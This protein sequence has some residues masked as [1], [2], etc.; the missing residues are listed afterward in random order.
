MAQLT[1]LEL[2]DYI[3]T[4]HITDRKEQEKLRKR[5][6]LQMQ[7]A[8]KLP[9]AERDIVMFMFMPEDDYTIWEAYKY[10]IP[11]YVQQSVE[12]MQRREGETWDDYFERCLFTFQFGVKDVLQNYTRTL[13]L[14]P[15]TDGKTREAC[16]VYFM[17][18]MQK[19]WRVN[20]FRKAT[21]KP[22]P[23]HEYREV[24]EIILP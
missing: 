8:K 20:K 21:R 18:Y 4:V 22:K 13:Q 11:Y 17:T 7:T 9:M 19:M 12:Y 3:M 2:Y 5:L 24:K 1:A 23:E 6:D 16:R 10:N 15:D 14:D